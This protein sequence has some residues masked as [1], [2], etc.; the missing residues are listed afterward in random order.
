MGLQGSE[1][2]R[3]P[4]GIHWKRPTTGQPGLHDGSGATGNTCDD[5]ASS[6]PVLDTTLFIDMEAAGDSSV[7]ISNPR[8]N[9]YTGP[10]HVRGQIK[11]ADNLAMRTHA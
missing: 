3:A 2:P 5:G 6:H 11:E 1:S 9:Y 4:A 7:T 10:V 8:G